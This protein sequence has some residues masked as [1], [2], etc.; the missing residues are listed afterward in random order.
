MIVFMLRLT[1]AACQAFQ[2]MRERLD[3]ARETY[4]MARDE[5]QGRVSADLAAL[6]R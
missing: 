6:R 4:G 1:H 2:G 3:V 5:W